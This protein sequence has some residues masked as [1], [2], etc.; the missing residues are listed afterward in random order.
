MSDTNTSKKFFVTYKYKDS[1]V[2]PLI[3]YTPGEDTDYLYTPRHYVD[4]IIEIVGADNIYK[5]EK[6][7]EDMGHLSDDTIDSK[8]KQKIFDSSVTIVLISPNMW[9]KTKLE[10]DQW[11]PNEILYSLRDK[12]RGGRTSKTN[13]ML[14][15][16]LPDA[17][18][19]Y[20]YAVSKHTCLYCNSR[21]WH[22]GSY[23]TLLRKNMFNR[24]RKNLTSCNYCLTRNI[25]TGEDHS[26][27]YP[28]MWPDFIKNHNL[29]INHALVLRERLEEFD[30]KR[31]YEQL[32]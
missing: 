11:I 28:V 13:G 20:G 2:L 19:K 4:K 7:D 23:F 32:C 1:D 27:V 8:L 18:G 6:G 29:Y 9:D 14:A 17:N 12:T 30:L 15:V 24:I 5:G 31:D 10:K 22:I 21:I 3:E 26:F 16:I 25:N